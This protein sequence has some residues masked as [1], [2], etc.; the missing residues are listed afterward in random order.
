M[1]PDGNQVNYDSSN[2]RE[3][4]I[5]TPTHFMRIVH[6]IKQ[7]SLIFRS[8]Q[9]GTVK[10][11]GKKYSESF[12]RCSD[13]KYKNMMSDFTWKVEGDRLY[14]SGTATYQNGKKFMIK[15][16]I[17]LREQ[18][19][20]SFADNPAIGTWDQLSSSFYME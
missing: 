8:S 20:K 13:D 5:I 10:I 9:S 6:E 14:A 4:K 15:E 1:D 17:F 18:A 7:D 11:D 3:T 16:S 2:L 19:G 12:D